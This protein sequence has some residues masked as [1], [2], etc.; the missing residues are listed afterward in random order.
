MIL[1]A[2]SRLTFEG[3]QLISQ[4]QSYF[5]DFTN[6]M[7][8]TLFV[9]SIIFVWVFHSDCLC[10]LDWQWQVGVVAVFLAW[11]VLIFFISKLPFAGI[12]VLM[13]YKIFK[14]FLKMLSL[15]FLLVLAFGLT[16][17]LTFHQPEILVCSSII[18][19]HWLNIIL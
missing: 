6:W 16:F 7:E 15:T 19:C 14:T 12:Y 3:I 5:K 9:C 8:M 1:S 17:Y 13:F 11:I 18:M 4:Y 10:P 2:L